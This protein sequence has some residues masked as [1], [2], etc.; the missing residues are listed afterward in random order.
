MHGAFAGGW[1]W[2]PLAEHAGGE[3]PHGRGARPPRRRPGPH[4]DRRDHPRRLRQAD[5]RGARRAPRAGRARRP[6]HGRH[7]DHPGRP[8]LRRPDRV[9][10][11]RRRVPAP[12]RREPDRPDPAARGRGRPGAGQP[13][14]EGRPA[15][16]DDARRGIARGDLRALLRRD[17]GL[18]DRQPHAAAGLPVHRAGGARRLRLRRHPARVRVL[19][20]GPRDPAAAAA[21]HARRGRLLRRSSSWTPTTCPQLSRTA[22]LA[23]ALHR[24][25]A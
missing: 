6:Q 15:G 5:L 1:V 13:R 24:L 19:R 3:G 9:D 20:A 14:R 23:E 12:G 10:G 25:A 4:A 16:G 7:G 21:A 11:L 8:A 18:G 22:E 2:G 17:G